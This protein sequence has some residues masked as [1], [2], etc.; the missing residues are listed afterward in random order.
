MSEISPIQSAK[1]SPPKMDVKNSAGSTKPSDGFDA[2]LP[3]LS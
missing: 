2:S 3:Y 1:A